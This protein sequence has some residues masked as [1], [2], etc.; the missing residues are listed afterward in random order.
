MKADILIKKMK[1][2]DGVLEIIQQW[3]NARERCVSVISEKC[4]GLD[5]KEKFHG[6]MCNECRLAYR[7]DLRAKARAARLAEKEKV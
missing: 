6:K 3:F 2:D 1:M 4:V 5:L 7:R